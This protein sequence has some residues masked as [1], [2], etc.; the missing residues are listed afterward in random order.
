M[1]DRHMLHMPYCGCCCC[2]SLAS[3]VSSHIVSCSAAVMLFLFA[4]LWSLQ[5]PVTS[6]DA[7]VQIA[8]ILQTIFRVTTQTDQYAFHSY[9]F[10]VI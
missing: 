4:L 5:T 2:L 1:I 9:I 8:E 3:L 6:G 10:H 7:I